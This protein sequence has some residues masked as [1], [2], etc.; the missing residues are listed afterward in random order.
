VPNYVPQAPSGLNLAPKFDPTSMYATIRDIGY[1]MSPGYGDVLAGKRAVEAYGRMGT[2]LRDM[3]LM[4]AAS[5]GAQGLTEQI[6]TIPGLGDIAGLAKIGAAGIM[7]GARG[8]GRLNPNRYDKAE[9]LVVDTMDF[10][11]KDIAKL[12]SSL[13]DNFKAYFGPETDLRS[14]NWDVTDLRFEIP[15]WDIA[16]DMSMIRPKT[17]M[18][19]PKEMRLHDFI[20]HPDLKKAYPDYN[21]IIIGARL[22]KSEEAL[23]MTYDIY[24]N[25]TDIKD[26]VV[27]EILLNWTQIEK[28]AMRAGRPA[29]DLAREILFHEIQHPIQNIEG[30][31]RGGHYTQPNYPRLGGEIEANVVGARSLRPQ[32]ENPVSQMPLTMGEQVVDY[33]SGPM[34]SKIDPKVK[35]VQDQLNL[36][37]MPDNY[38]FGRIYGEKKSWYF[39]ENE[40]GLADGNWGFGKNKEEAFEDYKKNWL[41]R[42][43]KTGVKRFEE[44]SH[45]FYE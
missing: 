45:N 17:R 10:G 42:F 5:Y 8:M 31:A 40:G 33:G 15:D 38:R 18:N 23:G 20:D 25:G 44:E 36:S 26:R 1:D 21:P 37:L 29:E 6:T 30:F 35:A 22:P 43:N 11:D 39:N 12:N 19:M 13:W 16:T 3:R 34:S 24:G 9:Q 14:G 4:D 41:K 7:A 27:P 32:T 28:E 2:A